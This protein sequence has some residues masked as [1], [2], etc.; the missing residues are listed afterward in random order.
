MVA[1]CCRCN[2]ICTRR[3][4]RH[5]LPPCPHANNPRTTAVAKKHPRAGLLHTFTRDGVHVMLLSNEQD[6]ASE[7]ALYDPAFRASRK[8]LSRLGASLVLTTLSSM[9]TSDRRIPV[10][11]E[12]LAFQSFFVI[13]SFTHSSGFLCHVPRR[14]HAFQTARIRVIQCGIQRPERYDATD[15]AGALSTLPRSLVLRRIRGHIIAN[16]VASSIVLVLYDVLLRYAPDF[17][18][19]LNVTPISTHLPGHCNVFFVDPT[20]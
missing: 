9:T 10:S 12:A 4:H 8:Q 13:S 11:E 18:H 5:H 7:E 2:W 3:N 6:K 16:S 14:S 19:H 15:W 1:A 20:V 17:V